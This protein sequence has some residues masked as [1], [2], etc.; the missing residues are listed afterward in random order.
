MALKQLSFFLIRPHLATTPGSLKMGDS[1][2]SPKRGSSKAIIASALGLKGHQFDS[3]SQPIMKKLRFSCAPLHLPSGKRL[4][5]ELERSTIFHGKIHEL[6]MA[7]ASSSQTT[8]VITRPGSHGNLGHTPG[9]TGNG[10][11][12]FTWA[13]AG[14]TRRSPGRRRTWWIWGFTFPCWC[15]GGRGAWHG[16]LWAIR[17]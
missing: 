15:R 5:N 17:C 2:Q 7:M 10:R 3:Q 16:F 12:F 14:S 1:A 9:M 8:L 13:S 4:H 6:S 11:A